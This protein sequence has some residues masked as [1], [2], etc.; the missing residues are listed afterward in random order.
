MNRL[1]H[2]LTTLGEECLEIAKRCSKANRLGIWEIQP[3]Q[4]DTN[5][6][7]IMQEYADLVGMIELLQLEGYLPALDPREVTAKKIKFEE[8]LDYSEKCGM[9]TKS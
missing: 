8:F 5:A 1:E 3:G 6:R 9:L 4:E 2:M 7:R